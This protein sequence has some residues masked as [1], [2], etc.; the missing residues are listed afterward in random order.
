MK[1]AL[2]IALAAMAL[3]C[4]CDLDASENPSADGFLTRSTEGSKDELNALIRGTLELDPERGCVLLSGQPVVWPAGTTMTSSPPE[5]HLRNGLI[6]RPGD[7]ITG[8]GGEASASAI[9]QSAVNIE[10]DVAAALDCAPQTSI[11][12]FNTRGDGL[13]VASRARMRPCRLSQIRLRLALNETSRMFRGRILAVNTIPIACSLSGRPTITLELADRTVRS[14]QASARPRW[15]REG[16]TPPSG[17]PLVRLAPDG[18]AEALLVMRNWCGPL[19]RRVTFDIDLPSRGGK[20]PLE[21]RIRLGCEL[22]RQPV[23]LRV[24]PFEPTAE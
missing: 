16:S 20:A 17:W 12:V 11:A 14:T 1:Q 8:G 5:L 7:L 21:A 4:G 3:A 23:R 24:G 9:R 6:A 10:G 19:D 15:R 18:R 2:V 13:G 22:R